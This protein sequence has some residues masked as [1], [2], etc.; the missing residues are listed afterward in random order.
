MPKIKRPFPKFS[1]KLYIYHKMLF[2]GIFPDRLKYAITKPLPKNDD[3]C[4]L[5]KYRTVSIST[6]DKDFKTP[7]QI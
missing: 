3:R 4:D 2:W 1:N 5:S 6:S 7:H